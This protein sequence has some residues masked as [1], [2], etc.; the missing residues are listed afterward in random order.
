MKKSKIFIKP[1][2]ENTKLVSFKLKSNVNIFGFQFRLD[3]F[4]ESYFHQFKDIG[5]I[6]DEKNISERNWNKRSI[7]DMYDFSVLVN[8][9]SGLIMAFSMNGNAIK[10]GHH[11][12]FS[13]PIENNLDGK[14]LPRYC[15]RDLII[16]DGSGKDFKTLGG[17][18][19]GGCLQGESK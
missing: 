17:K 13:I 5:T 14:K 19:D 11:H 18:Y 2:F 16:S 4:S 9:S 1:V 7:I 12:L 3:G 8:S 15:I 10:S 6:K